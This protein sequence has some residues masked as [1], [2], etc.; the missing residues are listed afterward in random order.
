MSEGQLG[1]IHPR[2][3]M[4]PPINAL[5]LNNKDNVSLSYQQAY[6]YLRGQELAF[7]HSFFPT[8]NDLES[9]LEKVRELFRKNEKDKAILDGLTNVNLKRFLPDYEPPV[10]ERG[11]RLVIHGDSALI[12]FTKLNSENIEVDDNGQIYISVVPE[13][14]QFIKSIL[15][16]ALGRKGENGSRNK[17]NAFDDSNNKITTNLSKMLRL[18][19]QQ[20]SKNITGALKVEVGTKPER[21]EIEVFDVVKFATKSNGSGYWTKKEMAE[22]YKNKNSEEAKAAREEIKK[23]ILYIHDFLFKDYNQASPKMQK[24]MKTVWNQLMGG[25]DILQQDFFFEGQNYTKI[26]LG[27]IGEFAHHVWT[28][29]LRLNAEDK[30]IP[31]K[32]VQ[33]IGSDFINGQQYHSDLEIMLACGAKVNQQTKN[34]NEDRKIPVNTNAAL[35][36]PLFGREI[37][38]PLVNYFAALDYQAEHGDL[39]KYFKQIFENDFYSAMN[40]NVSSKLNAVAD[41]M[42]TFYFIGGRNLIPGS[43]IIETLQKRQQNNSGPQFEISGGAVEG[44]TEEDFEKKYKKHYIWRYEKGGYGEEMVPS[45]FNTPL[46]QKDAAKISIQTSFSIPALL[47][48]GNFR[49]F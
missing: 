4:G 6:D 19:E 30:A 7:Y 28:E 13:N 18:T 21:K 10:F 42:N 45:S 25:R 9:F 24:A 27:Q 38:S 36:E 22:L 46:Y 2:G 11:Y 47:K 37:I 12:D 5:I 39:L 31:P 33:I 3:S 43:V 23:A 8:V 35:V 20:Q 40:L 17:I 16:K 48:S 15:N 44:Y 26:V 1:V 49:I 32:L 34:V 29:Y 14:A 41:Q